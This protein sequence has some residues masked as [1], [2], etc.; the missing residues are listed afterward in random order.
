MP[1]ALLPDVHA[2][3]AAYLA[4]HADV[5]AALPAHP[6]DPDTAN[7]VADVAGPYPCLRLV[8]TP[9]GTELNLRHRVVQEL[10]VEAWGDPDA[11]PD[12]TA[13]RA[14]LYVALR[15][16]A[17]LAEDDGAPVEGIVVS[18]V[19]SSQPGTYLPDPTGQPRYLAGVTI[20]AHPA[21]PATE[22]D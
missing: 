7:V 18:H 2:A 4:G 16:L 3:V 14:V 11:A 22:E 6:L 10:L 15:A 17:E 21:T 1:P 12:P 13:L 19:A 8:G 5:R 20:T 9:A